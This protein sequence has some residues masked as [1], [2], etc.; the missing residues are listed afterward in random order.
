MVTTQLG[1]LREELREETEKEMNGKKPFSWLFSYRIMSQLY[2]QS[3]E[4]KRSGS[5]S[6]IPEKSR[7]DSNR[8]DEATGSSPV[9]MRAP[10]D[11]RSVCGCLLLLRFDCATC[12]ACATLFCY[13][14]SRYLSRC[15]L[16]SLFPVLACPFLA[17][18]SPLFGLL[19][20]L[21]YF[22]SS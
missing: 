6:P 14:S 8:I 22:F 21:S 3:Q 11:N 5:L 4:S 13:L 15:I 20:A 17:L 10:C 7:L 9:E 1:E 18:E 19:R 2:L 12:A 16:P